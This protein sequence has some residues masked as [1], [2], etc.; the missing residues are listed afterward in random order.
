MIV[1]WGHLLSEGSTPAYVIT[2]WP[3]TTLYSMHFTTDEVYCC[4]V[5][6]HT[7]LIVEFTPPSFIV[8]CILRRCTNNQRL[9][10]DSN[11]TLHAECPLTKLNN[12][13]TIWH[14]NR[15]SKTDA[16][17]SESPHWSTL[18]HR[19]NCLLRTVVCR[20]RRRQVKPPLARL[21]CT[22]D[23]RR[24]GRW[25]FTDESTVT[26]KKPAALQ[27]SSGHISIA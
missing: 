3:S 23:G 26:Q 5:S 14:K 6:P 22:Q 24:H 11:T 21:L 15:S 2:R 12:P 9:L 8:S 17:N 4:I 16:D 25:N 18:L 27:I 13:N 1:E 20:V 19:G 10:T 7:M